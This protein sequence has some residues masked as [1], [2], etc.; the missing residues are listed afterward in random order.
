[1]ATRL[2]LAER[3]AKRVSVTE[4]GCWEWL[5]ALDPQGYGRISGIHPTTGIRQPLLV[6]RACYE[7]H[8]GSIPDG[9]HLD[10]LC[11]NRKCCNPEH[12]EPV[13]PRENMLR[14]EHRSAVALRT[15][16]CSRGH[17]IEPGIECVACVKIRNDARG[18]LT[19]PRTLA[20]RL[21]DLSV[22]TDTGCREW[23]GATIQGMGAVRVGGKTVMA[24]RAAHELHV[25]PVPQRAPV[26]V[27][28]GNRLCIE[29]THL[30]LEVKTSRG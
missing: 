3:L 6:H 26:K 24:R 22:V 9:L 19:R 11:R 29:P 2:T 15:G 10:H 8:V 16:K 27:T 28:C 25:G 7:A 1:M 21:A 23:T 18:R 30:R 20:E 12:L 5:G 4:S 17:D 14:S 13:T